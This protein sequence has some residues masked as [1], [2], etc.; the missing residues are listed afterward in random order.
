MI[1][2]IL[3][4]YKACPDNWYPGVDGDDLYHDPEIS[5]KYR[6]GCHAKER[7]LLSKW[8][9]YI[10]TG[11][12]GFSLGSPCPHVWYKIIDEVLEY[13]VQ[14]QNEGKISKF[15]IQ[16]IKMKF[17]GLRFYVSFECQDKV[18]DEQIRNE[19]SEMEDC[20]YDEK[21]VY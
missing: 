12:Y 9:P 19:I 16:Q 3:K 6:D 20:L 8:T 11:W 4:K 5:E 2:K 21:L 1:T 10:G 15:Q 17:G 18:L 14:L 13:F 7:D